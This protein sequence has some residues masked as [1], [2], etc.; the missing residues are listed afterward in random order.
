[1][2]TALFLNVLRSFPCS[3]L[4]LALFETPR[5]VRVQNTVA[6]LRNLCLARGSDSE[7]LE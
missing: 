4:R 1:M 3:E 7:G 2:A 5:R 6:A